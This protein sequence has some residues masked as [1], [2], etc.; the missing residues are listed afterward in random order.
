MPFGVLHRSE[1]QP[2]RAVKPINDDSNV[3]IDFALTLN[4]CSTKYINGKLWKDYTKNKQHGILSRKLRSYC[5][6]FNIIIDYN[7]YVFE[8]CP[9]SSQWHIHCVVQC[10]NLEDVFKMNDFINDAN[11]PLNTEYISSVI[12]RIFNEE[13]WQNYLNKD[14]PLIVN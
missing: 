12:K 11:K 2:I 9:K 8:K 5:N 4:L 3:L 7:R 1:F 14:Q 6:Q 13:G 10:T